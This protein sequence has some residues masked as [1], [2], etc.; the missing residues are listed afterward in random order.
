MTRNVFNNYICENIRKGLAGE[1]KEDEIFLNEE[2]GDSHPFITKTA[3]IDE[4]IRDEDVD[5]EFPY[6]GY[7]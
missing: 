5:S 4:Q 2:K 3:M 7:Y 1:I 6:P